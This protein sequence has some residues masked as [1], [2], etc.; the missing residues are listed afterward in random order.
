VPSMTPPFLVLQGIPGAIQ[1]LR[2][3]GDP[4]VANPADP[5]HRTMNYPRIWL[6]LFSAAGITHG[7]VPTVAL[8]FCAFYL[9]CISFL[10]VQSSH[11]MD[12]MILLLASLSV[13]PLL[14]MERGNTDLL[15]FSLIFLACVVTNKYLKSGLFGVAA[16]L[17]IFPMAAMML[18][19]IYRP[20]KER[21][22]AAL[23]TGIVLALILLQWHDLSL[24][25]KSTPVYR[26]RSF[27][28]FSLEEE[29]LFDTLQWGF[30]I[31]LGWVVVVECWLAGALAVVNAWRNRR[32]LDLSIQDSRF[33]E[34]FSVFGGTYVFT[35][36]VGGNFVYRL[37]FLLPTLPLVLEMVR[38]SRH[39]VWGIVYLVLMGL[40][41]NAIGF[42]QSGGT[43]AVHVAT[44]ALFIMLVGMLTRLF[45][46]SLHAPEGSAQMVRRP[47]PDVQAP[48]GLYPLE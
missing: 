38:S 37:I 44:F 2:Q 14:A 21:K 11:A 19:A 33:A 8:L 35:Y 5:M 25:R 9:A 24:I 41:E 29:V 10:I 7:S 28:I 4:L 6:Y 23:L 17:K 43:I 42:E 16:L 45:M 36:A 39:R 31:G 32:E 40:A 30:L 12:A 22:L 46:A 3:G 15:V 18:D 48:Q 34:M 27:G 1:T 13:G 20:R 47:S 26:A